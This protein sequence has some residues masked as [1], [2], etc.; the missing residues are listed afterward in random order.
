MTR[1]RTL[2]MPAIVLAYL[3]G[4]GTGLDPHPGEW[5]A[6]TCAPLLLAMAA[7]HEERRRE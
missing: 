5:A 2:W 1:P 6:A 7:L 3:V 4:L